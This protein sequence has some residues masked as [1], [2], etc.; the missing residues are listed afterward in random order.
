MISASLYE[1]NTRSWLRE[2]SD[3]HGTPISLAEVPDEE[4]R[5]WKQL[6]FSHIWL[7]G[8][9]TV[10]PQTRAHALRQPALIQQCRELW[11]DWSETDISGSPYAI[12]SYEVSR[13]LGGRK[14]LAA[15]RKKLHDHGLKLILDYVPNHLGLD[16]H[17]LREQP[18]LFVQSSTPRPGTFRGPHGGW[19]AHGKDPYFPAWTDTVQLDHRLSKTREVMI[20]Q[21]CEVAELCDGVRCDMAML[22]L[23][24]V[25]NRV[26]EHFPADR[27]GEMAQG[28]FW[29]EAIS[30]VRLRHPEFTFVAEAYWDREE[31]L[32]TLGFDFTY[33]KTVYDHIVR[34]E[35]AQLK[36]FLHG[37][38]STYL[39]RSVHFLENHDEP[40]IASLL[41]L[42]EHRAAALLTLLLPGMPL[43]YEGQLSGAT[44][45]SPIHAARSAP[46]SGNVRIHA[47]YENLLCVLAGNQ[48]RDGEFRFLEPRLSEN[49]HPNLSVLALAW[50]KPN[51][52][53]DLAL[54][55][56]QTQPVCF[57]LTLPREENWLL[58]KTNGRLLFGT[59][60]Q[61]SMPQRHSGSGLNAQLQPFE[62]QL[63]RLEPDN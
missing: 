44:T 24:D 32:Q 16:H 56:L 48:V 17:W 43:L 1:I 18:H 29:E 21:L 4:V 13:C 37:K 22:V 45:R 59:V 63:I 40:P 41:P 47:F 55:N 31:Q 6:G 51:L 36:K 62:A 33:N 53:L 57:D 11:P 10:G 42:P 23:S 27:D 12:G 14:G 46:F 34:R 30:I 28:E 60:G 9:W 19:L 15:F 54:V 58:R 52:K 61:P 7:M 3:K 25:F 20:K 35:P 8:V 49:S 5:Q 26:W 39:R 50:V 2:L 38:S